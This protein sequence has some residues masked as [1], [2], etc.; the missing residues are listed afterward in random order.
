MTVRKLTA[1]VAAPGVPFF[2]PA[3]DPPVGTA[4]NT[5]NDNGAGTKTPTVFTPLK[6]RSL[7]LQNRFAVSP[8][9]MYSADDGH[10]TDFHLVHLGA[11]AMRGVALTIFEA[12][13]V[14]PNGRISP[15]DS[16]L[17]TD[18][19]IAPLKRIVDFIHSQGQKAGIQLAHAGRKA[20]TVAP[21]HTQSRGHGEAATAAQG[22]WPDNVWAP[23]AIKFSP[24]FPQPK[25]MTVSEVEGLVDSFAKAASR[26]VSAGFD[27]I[28]IHA[29]HGY[30]LTEFLSPI[31][32]K[33]TDQYGGSFENRTRLLVDVIKATRAVIPET[34]PLLVRISATEWM[35][36]TGGE[37]WD[38]AQSIRLAKL[39]PDLGVDLL[40]VSSAGNNAE[41][42]MQI[43]PTVQIDLASEIRDAVRAAGKTLL[44]GAVGFVNTAEIAR[45]V[46]QTDDEGLVDVDGEHGQKTKADLVLVARQFLKEPEFVLRAAHQLG[47]EVK[48]P[49]QYGRAAWA[50]GEKL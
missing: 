29:A 26:A 28:E 18:S 5:D 36:W 27:T 43:T 49:L 17:W 20:S 50:K 32:N 21:W 6:L 11:M 42:R 8:M 7:T 24:K 45:R 41:Q 46:V 48:W 3:Q 12:T 22:G 2:T 14:T 39:L 33:R 23:S 15:E 35:E 31:T 40:D 38:L 44:I 9:C 4:L 25:E 30:L 10:L 34:M 37:S 13:S 47:V 1:T 19:Q 16:G